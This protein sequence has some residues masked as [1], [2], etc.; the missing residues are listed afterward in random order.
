MA[1]H[2]S[3]EIS[4]ALRAVTDYER[5]IARV[6][7]KLTKVKK[8]KREEDGDGDGGGDGVL[9][10]MSV[11]L[12]QT[13]SQSQSQSQQ[14][15]SQSL[16]QPLSQC[17]GAADGDKLNNAASKSA[18]ASDAEAAQLQAELLR[19]LS[20]LKRKHK[21]AKTLL[22]D[23]RSRDITAGDPRG[24]SLTTHAP[25]PG[26]TA[27]TF[28]LAQSQMLGT[29]KTMSMNM[30]IR[31]YG[32]GTMGMGQS[33]VGV[34]G[35]GAIPLTIRGPTTN[36][37]NA[38]NNFLHQNT[39]ISLPIT[40]ARL[41]DTHVPVPG[42]SI[43]INHHKFPAPGHRPY[44]QPVSTVTPAE[45][46]KIGMNQ[47]SQR[48]RNI[49]KTQKPIPDA[50]RA[51]T[52]GFR[53]PEILACSN[54]P[55]TTAIDIWSVGVIMLSL[56][57]RRYPFFAGAHDFVNL[58]EMLRLF[59]YSKHS[60]IVLL[61]RLI[62]LRYLPT[63]ADGLRGTI[64]ALCDVPWPEELLDLLFRCLEL[65][66]HHRITAREALEHPFF[67]MD[68]RACDMTVFPCAT[69]LSDGGNGAD[70]TMD[71]INAYF[72]KVEAGGSTAQ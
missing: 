21:R 13:L 40:G 25:A 41:R 48:G 60:N 37:S 2:H 49:T 22:N 68:A 38:R 65:T 15:Q 31:G 10:Q 3:M 51:G 28:D 7:D 8:R 67:A 46:I 4:N 23:V 70:V 36:M 24:R 72:Q 53:A 19:E 20:E 17:E 66:P 56:L 55:Q 11:E 57:T 33:G 14:S 29:S 5:R 64:A 12:S 6:E 45:Q 61:D 59:G 26:H 47:L 62:T 54:V 42:G 63:V 9:S 35:G 16:S 52:R 18:S 34:V 27:S 1:A 58:C 69:P 71:D 32:G 30:G 39:G 44:G 43:P 50:G